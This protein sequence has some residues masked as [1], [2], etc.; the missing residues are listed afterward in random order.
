M[1][2][3]ATPYTEPEYKIPGYTGHVHGLGETYAQTPVPAQEETMHPPPTSLLWT[4]ST[5]ATITLPLKEDGEKVRVAQPPRQAVNL[6]PN[7]QNT[8]KQETAKP[9]SSNL[10]LGDSRINPFITSYSQD[11]DSPF[12][13][14]RTLRSPL[15]NKNLG[16]VADLKEVYSSAFQRVGDK[17]LNH[18]VEHMKERLAGKI[19]NASDNAF[20]LRRLFK[21]YDTQHSG[22]IGIEDFR[23]MTESFGMQ[24]DD[25]SLLALFS[26][27][28]P[29]ATGVIEYTT[30]MKNLL[31]KDYYA[32]YI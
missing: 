1:P 16:S 6:W 2:T 29:K 10:T 21:M 7:L 11:F 23:V 13:S 32:L 19:G 8:G 28:D 5:L 25:D 31:D 26:R 24:L 20:R 9:P 27:Y 18:M 3:L 30:L 17:R 4:R 12:V 15:R 22:R 14:G